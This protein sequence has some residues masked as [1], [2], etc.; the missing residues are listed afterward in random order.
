MGD[1]A[2]SVYTTARGCV[3]RKC[4]ISMEICGTVGFGLIRHSYRIMLLSLLPIC[5]GVAASMVL[6]LF[7]HLRFIDLIEYVV[8]WFV[9]CNA[10]N[11][12]D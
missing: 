6:I 10:F 9:L 2:F 7:V 3:Q 5:D 8:M 12:M 4:S 1:G 11:R